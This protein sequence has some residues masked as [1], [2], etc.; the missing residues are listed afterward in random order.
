MKTLILFILIS[1]SSFAQIEVIASS[2]VYSSLS[3]VV[4]YN[5]IKDRALYKAGDMRYE[6]YSRRWHSMKTYEIGAGIGTGIVIALDSDFIPEYILTDL[7][8]VGA[9]R[10]IVHDGVYNLAQGNSFFYQSPNTTSQTEKLGTWY[11]KL[12]T[13]GATIY[14]RKII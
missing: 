14:L 12:L 4:T 8:I 6:L 11:I 5:Q 3:G 13:L 1:V 2:V 9:V 10:W 7:L